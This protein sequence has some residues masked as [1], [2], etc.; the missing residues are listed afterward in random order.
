MAFPLR[1]DILFST[2]SFCSQDS[3][4]DLGMLMLPEARPIKYYSKVLSAAFSAH[5][6]SALVLVTSTGSPNLALAALQYNVPVY[7]WTVKVKGHALHHRDQVAIEYFL[8]KQEPLRM[9]LTP[10]LKTHPR[11]ITCVGIRNAV[12]L[13]FE[14]F[15]ARLET[16][17]WS[18]LDLVSRLLN[19]LAA[20]EAKDWGLALQPRKVAHGRLGVFATKRLEE[21]SAF[22]ATAAMFTTKETLLGLN[23]V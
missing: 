21:A 20:Q 17:R 22:V 7:L 9:A 1:I 4:L 3:F 2:Y 16:D 19:N 6:A 14:D 5:H 10:T 12:F 13:G 18:G 8:P 15:P 23:D 11:Y